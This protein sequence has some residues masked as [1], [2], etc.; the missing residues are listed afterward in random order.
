MGTTFAA[1]DDVLVQK[2]LRVVQQIRVP[3]GSFADAAIAAG[4]A[5][6]HSK[7]EHRYALDYAQAPGTAIVA[8]TIDLHTAY[9]AGGVLAIKGTVTGVIATGA[10]RTVTID[11][12]KS[13]AG[14]AFATV[15]AAPI[16]LDNTNVLR[17]PEAGTV[18]VT[19]FVADDLLRLLITV[20]GAAGNQGE[21]LS[22]VAHIWEG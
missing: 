21:G 14:G 15:L 22:V 6:D 17:T 12:H 10:D 3:D 19:T 13:T 2:S 5:I 4:A 9:S 18:T 7:V 20:A 11:L 16:V 8:A 1:T